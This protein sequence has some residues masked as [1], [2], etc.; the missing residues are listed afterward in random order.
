MVNGTYDYKA[1]MSRYGKDVK[2]EWDKIKNYYPHDVFVAIATDHIAD[3]GLIPHYMFNVVQ[4][5]NK[6]LHNE[7][8][9]FDWLTHEVENESKPFMSDKIFDVA[10]RYYKD[11]VRKGKNTEGSL[12]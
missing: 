4:L 3:K 1:F 8:P 7:I 5:R 2:D 11:L 12:V 9:Y 6:F 10:E